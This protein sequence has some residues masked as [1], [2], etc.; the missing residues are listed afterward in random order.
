MDRTQNWHGLVT[1][2]GQQHR[3]RGLLRVAFGPG[4]C[5]RLPVFVDEIFLG[6]RDPAFR[7]TYKQKVGVKRGTFFLSS[8]ERRRTASS[9]HPG[10]RCTYVSHY[11]TASR[12]NQ[13]TPEEREVRRTRSRIR[14]A[15][16]R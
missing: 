2:D 1:L 13:E 9:R 15:A 16:V 3:L 11:A 8:T 10:V 5:P 7:S 6:G 12:R 4:L 14:T